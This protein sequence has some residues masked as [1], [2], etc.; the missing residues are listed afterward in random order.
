MLASASAIIGFSFSASLHG[1][2]SAPSHPQNPILHRF[3]CVDNGTKTAKLIH[4]DQTRPDANWVVVLPGEGPRDL[5]WIG[6]GSVL[7]SLSR[8]YGEYDL[9]TGKELRKVS[10]FKGITTARRLKNGHTLLAGTESNFIVI[11]EVDTDGKPCADPCRIPCVGAPLRQMRVLPNGNLLLHVATDTVAEVDPSGKTVWTLH[12]PADISGS[13][14][15]VA[16][17]LSDGSTLTSLGSGV[18]VAQ[19]DAQGHE[20]RFWGEKCKTDHPE[21]KLDYASGFDYLPN[22][23]VVMSNWQGHL[24]EVV[25]PHLV[26]FDDANQ[27][28]WQWGDAQKARQVTN[29]LVL[30]TV[31]PKK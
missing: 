22:G 7:V 11:H 20:L 26:E 21:W 4:V 1:A 17:R 12:L 13:K 24:R 3:V 2:T 16:E 5:Q 6:N 30:D 14:G 29:V 25:G 10:A 23:H 8:G 9:N 18:R 15:T 27:L 19:Y 31:E 28:V